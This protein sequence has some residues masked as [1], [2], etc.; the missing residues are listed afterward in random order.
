MRIVN[1]VFLVLLVLISLAAGVPKIIQMPQ[2]LQ[3][4]A[5]LGFIPFAVTILGVIQFSGWILLLP[6]KTR[7]IGAFLAVAGLL[8]SAT[9]LLKGG[10]LGMGLISFIP[11]A[12]GIWVIFVSL[13]RKD[14]EDSMG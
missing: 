7:A 1:K 13:P 9:A 4:L 6:P 2:E 5:H 3:F 10:N 12:M 8:V 11:V 14:M